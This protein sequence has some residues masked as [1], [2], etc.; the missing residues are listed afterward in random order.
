MSGKIEALESHVSQDGRI[1]VVA[2]NRK[3]L[4]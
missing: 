1:R 3:L 2:V 4:P